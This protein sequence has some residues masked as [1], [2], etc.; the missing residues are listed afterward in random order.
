MRVDHEKYMFSYMSTFM[1]LLQSIS[2]SAFVELT[3][4]QPDSLLVKTMTFQMVALTVTAVV[5]L[6]GDV[7]TAYGYN[8][9]PMQADQD[10]MLRTPY[11]EGGSSYYVPTAGGLSWSVPLGGT[12]VSSGKPIWT[13][14]GYSTYQRPFDYYDTDMSRSNNGWGWSTS[15]SSGYYNDNSYYGYRQDELQGRSRKTWSNSGY[16]RY[17]GVKD[18]VVQMDSQ[19][20]P[21]SASVEVWEG[22]NYTPL[23]V[24]LYSEDGNRRPFQTL[25]ETPRDGRPHA[26]SVNNKGPQEMPL[27]AR[28]TSSYRNDPNSYYNYGPPMDIRRIRVDGGSLKTVTL[29]YHVQN[30]KLSLRSQGGPIKATVELWEGP[31]AAKQVAE[32]DSQDGLNKPFSAM[33][34]T[35]GGTTVAVRNTGPLEF[36]IDMYVEMFGYGYQ[37]YGSWGGY[38][39]YGGYSGYGRGYGG[40]GR[41]Y[42]R[43]Y[44][45]YY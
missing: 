25:V 23:K 31:G 17:G 32:V 20:R 3:W 41:G 30:V 1:L 34:D 38:G 42:G 10:T 16:D 8:M 7:V 2:V 19:G 21:M 22:P 29:P 24:N 40:Y 36:P 12:S 9:A 18:T 39:G 14:R 44:G 15:S 35:S 11:R 13:D 45:G 27:N 28:V 4:G 5:M 33:I 43:S 6:C 37:T 26:V